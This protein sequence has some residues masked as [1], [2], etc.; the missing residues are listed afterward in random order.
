V[1]AGIYFYVL[2]DGAGLL[3]EKVV[4]LR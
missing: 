3:R 4:R 2:R 1:P